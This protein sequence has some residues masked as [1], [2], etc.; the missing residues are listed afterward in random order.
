MKPFAHR[1]YKSRT[2]KD[3]RE[4]YFISQHGICEQCGAGGKIVHHTEELTPQNIDDP[5][6]TLNWEVLQLLCQ[7]CH[8]QE[9]HSSEVVDEGLRF[10]ADGDLVRR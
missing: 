9:H 5:T 10:D 6:V 8:N 1:F 7:D 4:A 2:W 3:C